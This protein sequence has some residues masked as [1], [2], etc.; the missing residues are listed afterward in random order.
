[1]SD[2]RLAGVQ[3][4]LASRQQGLRAGGLARSARPLPVLPALGAGLGVGTVSTAL[5]EPDSTAY[6]LNQVAGSAVVV[7]QRPCSCR[8][9]C[10]HAHEVRAPA[11]GLA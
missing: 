1:M 6:I 8:G 11:A 3:P 4:P 7:E 2:R 9:S 5:A 10:N